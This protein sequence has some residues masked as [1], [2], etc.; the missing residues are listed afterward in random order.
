M[1]AG[2]ADY[3][4]APEERPTFPGSPA[5]P[6]HPL[7][8]RVGY[9]AVALL[10]GIT[11]TLGNALVN[12]NIASLSGA[13]GVYVEQATW[14]PAIY[15]AFNASAGLTLIKARAQFGIPKVTHGSLIAYAAAALL[16]FLFPS[17]ASAVVVRAVSG[18]AASSLVTMTIYSLMQVFPAKTRAMA[19]VIGVGLTQLGSPIARMVPVEMLALDHWQS[20]H[21]IELAIALA[22][23][24]ALWTLPLPPSVCVKSFEP[25]DFV[26]IALVVPAMTLVCGV[27]SEG[28]LLWWMDTPGL[29]WALVTAVP[30]FSAAAAIEWYRANPLIQ[31]RWIGTGEMLRFVFVALVVR[32]ALAEQTYGAVG[33]LTSGGLTNDQLRI[34]FA[35]VVVAMVMGILVASAIFSE[36]RLPKLVFAAA[37]LIAFGAWIDS[38]ATNLVRPPQLY[39]SQMLIA[40]GTTIFMGPALIY[41]FL[42]VLRLGANYLVTFIVLF[43]VTQNVG[44]LVGSAFLGSYQVAATQAH[45]QALSEHLLAN[46]PQVMA[47]LQSAGSAAQVIVDPAQRST[48][49]AALL[50]QAMT[51]EANILAYNDVFNLVALLS[52]AAAAFMAY[53]IAVLRYQR[54]RAQGASG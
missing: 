42:R 41:G 40:F 30:L 11:A 25:L 43:N 51:R 31:L 47:R 36:Q 13:M 1:T 15:V 48:Q 20:L 22:A 37:L 4:F 19:L 49:G 14:L 26:T 12:V 34:L 16:Q 24:A 46:N 21:L 32:L 10:V 52:L 17:F 44:G 54:T 2:V 28:R 45:L 50:A 6:T 8:R 38:S 3:Q 18:V 39:V 23:S 33:I 27:L 29:G 53:R 5:V 9:V 35:L 7:V